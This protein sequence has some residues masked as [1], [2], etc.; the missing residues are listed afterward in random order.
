MVV[1]MA[2][3]TDDCSYYSRE[4]EINSDGHFGV[5]GGD[6]PLDISSSTPGGHPVP[7]LETSS[8][9]AEREA[10]VTCC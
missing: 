8:Y 1:M 4:R 5:S 10:S 7:N 6:Q 3:R 2:H 9:Q